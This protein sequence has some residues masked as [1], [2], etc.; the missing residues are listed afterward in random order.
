MTFKQISMIVQGIPVKTKGPVQT[1][2]TDSNAAVH[3]DFMEHNVKQV[4][5]TDNITNE[6]NELTTTTTTTIY[7]YSHI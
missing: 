5:V 1:E 6:R 2:W 3:Q 4:I 7:W